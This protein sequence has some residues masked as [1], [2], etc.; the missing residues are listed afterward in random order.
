MM[1][2]LVRI[3]AAS[4]TVLIIGGVAAAQVGSPSQNRVEPLPVVVDD[5]PS[6]DDLGVDVKGPC[7]EAEHANDPRCARAGSVSD[8][9]SSTSMPASSSSSSVADATST[10][11]DD[12]SSPSFHDTT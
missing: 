2:R 11:V 4:S 7:D 6:A 12:S 10:T 3:A 9:S 1:Q 8:D 5:N